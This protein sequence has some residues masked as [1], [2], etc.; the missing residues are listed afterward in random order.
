VYTDAAPYGNGLLQ[1]V[2]V[3]PAQ[4]VQLTATQA[5]VERDRE[6]RPPSRR[7]RLQESLHLH[8]GELRS[9]YAPARLLAPVPPRQVGRIRRH[10]AHFLTEGEQSVNVAANLCNR[11]FTQSF[12]A[13]V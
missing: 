1:Q 7:A 2:D 6:E 12:R 9:P 5:G 11:P 4:P 8:R 3:A 10:H 13:L